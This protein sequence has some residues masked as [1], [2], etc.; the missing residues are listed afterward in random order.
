MTAVRVERA[1]ALARLATLLADWPEVGLA[2]VGFVLNLPWELVHTPLYADVTGGAWWIL[3]T[4]VHCT[5]GDVMILLGTFWITA[6]L[7]R[8]RRWWA[9][10]Q[11]APLMVFVALGFAYTVYSEWHNTKVA[12]GWSYAPA[13]PVIFGIGLSPLLQWLVIPPLTIGLMRRRARR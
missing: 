9:R 8:D 2:G 7:F 1:P 10:E 12:G 4:R 13:M 3:W 11:R 5:I 6:A